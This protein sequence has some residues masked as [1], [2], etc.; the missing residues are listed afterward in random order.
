MQ[1]IGRITCDAGRTKLRKDNRLDQRCR[2]FGK[3]NLRYQQNSASK[4]PAAG[5]SCAKLR[6]INRQNPIGPKWV[7]DV[8]RQAAD[9]NHTG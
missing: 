5:I 7:H 8:A 2:E 3:L 1:A 6:V 4:G 9:R